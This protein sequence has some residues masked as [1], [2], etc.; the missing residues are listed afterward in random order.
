MRERFAALE[1]TARSLEPSPED[2]RILR[3]AVVDYTEKFIDEI[4]TLPAYNVTEDKGKEIYAS[5]I[6]EE[7]MAVAEALRI[8]A[9]NVDRPG[10]NPASHGHLAYIPGGGIYV[11]AIADYLADITNRY[12]GVFYGGPGAVRME[13]MLIGWMAGIVGYPAA[14]GGNLTSGGSIANLI[15]IVAARD[16]KGITAREVEKSVIYLTDQAHHSVD[17]AI[18]IAG[19]AEC[20]IRRIPI[21]KEY[22]MDCEALERTLAADKRAGLHPFLIIASAG[23]TDTGAV[24]PLEAIGTLAAAHDCWFHCDGAYGAFFILCDE[25]KGLLAGM[26]KADSLVMDPHKGLFLPYGTGAVLVRDRQLLHNSFWYQASYLLDAQSGADELS[27]ADLSPELTKHFRGLRLWLPLK[28]H[29]LRPFRACLEEKILLARYFWEEIQKV[30]RFEVG[31]YPDLSVV[32]YR[33]VPKQGDADEFNKRLIEEI[34]NDGRVFLS[35]T[36]LDGKFVLRLAVLAFRTH[37]QTIDLT[38][39]LLAGYAK[40]LEQQS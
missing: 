21:T 22:R 28:I 30:D 4:Y 8:Y 5:P 26:Q 35:S 33:Y 32:T 1:R 37:L 17:K 9:H 24:D 27:P 29:G 11:S 2:R 25:V 12:A 38:L 40:K 13:N 36:R 39:Q 7:P 34:Q 20:P 3:D 23:T 6:E 15:G 10:L 31:A 18:R 14:C 16:A 19:L